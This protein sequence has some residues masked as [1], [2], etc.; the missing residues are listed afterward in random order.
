[1]KIVDVNILIY[2]ASRQSRFHSQVHAWWNN[3][4][5]GDEPIGLCWPVLIGFLRIM[6]HPGILPTPLSV[7]QVL[8]RIEL[9]LNHPMCRL[10]QETENHWQI[11]QRV[12]SDASATGNL[13]TD[14][15]LAALAISRGATL[16][17]CD[18]DFR[19]FHQL[20]WENPIG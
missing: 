8:A 11:L 20:R 9:W 13:T 10:V 12:I 1:M 5:N 6:T 19:R 2:T 15:H 17:S 16:V 14:A 7:D 4:L 18:T 3:A